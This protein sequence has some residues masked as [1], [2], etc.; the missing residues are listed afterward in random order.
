MNETAEEPSGVEKCEIIN[1]DAICAAL[2]VHLLGHIEQH[3]TSEKVLSPQE[4]SAF[5]SAL[6]NVQSVYA[7]MAL[8]YGIKP[9]ESCDAKKAIADAFNKIEAKRRCCE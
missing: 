2:A 1:F 7:E 8:R 5:A 4:I 9:N 6:E 3:L